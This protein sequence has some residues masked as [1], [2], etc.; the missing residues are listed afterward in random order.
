[1]LAARRR[2]SV[3]AVALGVVLG[4]GERVADLPEDEL[5]PETLPVCMLMAGTRGYW[6]DGKSGIVWDPA[7][8]QTPAIC[9]CMTQERLALP[10]QTFRDGLTE[11]NDQM[12]AE[13]N[14]LSDLRAFDWDDCLQ[15]Y[16]SGYW[17]G[18]TARAMPGDY[19]AF[20]VPPDLHCE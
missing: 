5:E 16:E 15:D 11:L 4:C 7:L 18:S 19:W 6:D 8:E 12:L 9:E 20:I 17:R 1:M 3:S 14:R 2:V 10:I 13:C